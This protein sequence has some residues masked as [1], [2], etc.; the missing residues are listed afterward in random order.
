MI[1]YLVADYN[2]PMGDDGTYFACETADHDYYKHMGS[3][4]LPRGQGSRAM[5]VTNSLSAYVCGPEAS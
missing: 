2:C 4:T 3:A 5:E 1:I